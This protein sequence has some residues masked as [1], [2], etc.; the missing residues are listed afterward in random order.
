MIG[1]EV[2]HILSFSFFYNA[3]ASQVLKKYAHPQIYCTVG[4][5]TK[6]GY[7]AKHYGIERTHI[8]HSRDASFLRDIMRFTNDRGVDVVL[9]SLSGD[10]L[11]ASWMCVAEFGT[12]IEI[13]KR[14]FQRR[15]KLTMEPFEKNRSFAGFDLLRIS[16]LQPERA[17]K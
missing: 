11:R 8:L 10:L 9:N 2:S 5:E 12:M 16:Q 6:A 14:D 4:S 15:A 17:I 7:L 13:S 3:R 1:A